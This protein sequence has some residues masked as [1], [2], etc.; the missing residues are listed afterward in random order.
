MTF[1]GELDIIEHIA[2]YFCGLV[3]YLNYDT[4]ISETFANFIKKTIKWLDIFLSLKFSFS[5]KR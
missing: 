5:R 1:L 3:F 2:E 4:P